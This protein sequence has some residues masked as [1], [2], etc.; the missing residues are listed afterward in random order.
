MFSYNVPDPQ[1]LVD[2]CRHLQSVQLGQDTELRADGSQQTHTQ[3]L[4]AEQE[5]SSRYTRVSSDSQ[6]SGPAAVKQS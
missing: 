6:A 2:D 1:T 3:E 5:G 4:S